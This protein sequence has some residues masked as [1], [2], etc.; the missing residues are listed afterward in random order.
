MTA[1]P[2]IDAPKN[3]ALGDVA[4]LVAS[5]FG[6]KCGTEQ[7]GVANAENRLPRAQNG[8]GYDSCVARKMA[9]FAIRYAVRK[10]KPQQ[11][12]GFTVEA[13]GIEDGAGVMPKA[14]VH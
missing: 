2:T 13:P 5:R 11:L 14:I 3:T 7:I 4:V 12:L 1:R 10:I 6:P 9:A 8:P